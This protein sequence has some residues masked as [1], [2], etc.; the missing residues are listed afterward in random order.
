MVPA[1]RALAE[2][3]ADALRPLGAGSSRA[4]TAFP[5]LRLA[6]YDAGAGAGGG[7]LPGKAI[8]DGSKS[9]HADYEVDSK[10]SVD[11]VVGP[12]QGRVGILY[13]SGDGEFVLVDE[14]T[15]AETR[16]E[17]RAG[18]RRGGWRRQRWRQGLCTRPRRWCR[19]KPWSG[20][21]TAAD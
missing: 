17:V 11:D 1:P 2:R 20:L 10:F 8:R 4:A 18:S 16:Q 21:N 3:L 13:L 12:T 14:A 6:A 19:F 5:R 9:C 7:A 15:G